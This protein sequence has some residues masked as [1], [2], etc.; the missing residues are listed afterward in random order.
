PNDSSVKSDMKK[1]S[2]NVGIFNKLKNWEKF[3]VSNDSDDDS[4]DSD[5]DS[6]DSDYDSIKQQF[7]EADKLSK[8][9]AI[10]MQKHENIK[11]TSKPIDMK[12][13]VSELNNYKS[14]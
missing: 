13:I 9:M 10:I 3:I 11:Y 14:N 1:R 12:G 2:K 7:L 8:E 4:Y 5:D 6:Y